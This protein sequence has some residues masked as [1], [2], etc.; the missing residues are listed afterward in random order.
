MS[1][2]HIAIAGNIGSGKTTLTQLLSARLDWQAYY[3]NP[4]NN[5]YIADFYVDM[6]RWGFNMQVFFLYSRIARIQE[7]RNGSRHV[8][9]D[10]T[11]YED[12]YIFAPTLERMQLMDLRDYVCYKNLFD[13]I[14]PVI[15]PPDLLIYL[16]AP[17]S[18]LKQR[19]L[20]R[21]REYE[22]QVRE[23]YL[24]SLNEFYDR[25]ASE[26]A[27]GPKLVYDVETVDFVNNPD[28]LERIVRDVAACFPDV[29]IL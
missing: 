22:Q 14:R 20:S 6:P 17:G 23:D 12:V 15:Q 25:W 8:V 11:I 3:E 5:P 7:I 26:Y 24:D 28:D 19:I 18:V 4:D 21:N 2:K 10:R 27:L 13:Q 16:Q 29:A 9:Q 1:P